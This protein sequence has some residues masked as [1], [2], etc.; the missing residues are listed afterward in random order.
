MGKP[1]CR[2]RRVA[3]GQ[4]KR[5]P[6]HFQIEAI[7]TGLCGIIV[8]HNR[9][10]Y[11]FIYQPR[12]TILIILI[13]VRILVRTNCSK[14][15][16]VFWGLKYS[17]LHLFNKNIQYAQQWRLVEI[18]IQ[19]AHGFVPVSPFQGLHLAAAW[20]CRVGITAGGGI[21]HPNWWMELF[22]GDVSWGYLMGIWVC[23][24]MVYTPNEIAI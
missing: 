7:F 17:H 20:S 18:F 24:K 4:C 14:P 15:S 1:E 23:L 13:H 19:I 8:F 9:D 22:H 2:W 12:S 21:Y 10:N 5:R 16:N 3:H 6:T 11:M